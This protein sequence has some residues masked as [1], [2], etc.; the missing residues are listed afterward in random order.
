MTHRPEESKERPSVGTP[1]RGILPFYFELIT[2]K[3]LARSGWLLREI[4]R[5][6][7]ESVADHVFATA[8]LAL[9]L[10]ERYPQGLDRLRVLELVL[11]HELG[12]IDA[13]DLTPAD[14][15]SPNAKHER[16]SKGVRRVASLLSSSD[17]IIDL[18]NEY[19]AGE[20]PEARFVRQIDKL[21]MAFQAAAYERNSSR[22]L[23]EFKTSAREQI[24]DPMLLKLLDELE[25][26]TK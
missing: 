11:I 18:W 14:G 9:L 12:E 4:S 24:Q 17:R 7:C 5:E 13:G 6:D 8:F 15:L 20:T 1:D 19:E 22:N 16:E 26:E 23:E 10:S 25:A 2:L 21:E 3:N